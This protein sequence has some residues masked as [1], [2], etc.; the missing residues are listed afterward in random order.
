MAGTLRH[1][2]RMAHDRLGISVEAI[3]TSGAP[4]A[5]SLAEDDTPTRSPTAVQPLVPGVA[6]RARG[7]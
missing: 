4:F 1:S 6:P 7:L 2:L 5:V 3:P